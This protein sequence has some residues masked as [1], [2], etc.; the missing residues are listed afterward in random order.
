MKG[1]WKMKK[2]TIL[3]SIFL[4]MTVF[5]AVAF[6]QELG[7]RKKRP[8][9]HEYANVV[10]N[11]VSEKNNMAPV[12]YNHWLH[13]AKYTCRLCHVGLKFVMKAGATGISENANNQ[14]LYCGACHNGREAF[15]PVNKG[16]SGE[17]T[18]ENCDRCHSYGKKV[19][20]ERN[21]YKFTKDFPRA[22]FGN[23]INW[24]KTEAMGL[25][26]LK[27]Y[28][29]GVSPRKKME[30]PD[31]VVLKAKVKEMPDIIFSHDKHA[32]WNGCENCHPLIFSE[33]K[34]A[35]KFTMAEIFDGK[36]C[37]TCHGKVSFSTLDCQRCHVK[38]IL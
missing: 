30:K 21:F 14:G 31:E 17:K 6:S 26:N 7:F 28:L 13:R 22:R 1:G 33:K 27:D 10:I 32:V 2:I 12:V 15:A 16:P 38:R 3:T 5:I 9:Y 4:C 34:G 24:L 36:Y 18:G 35:N 20:F 37:G 19:K 11:N 8:A 23:G 29:E 25:V